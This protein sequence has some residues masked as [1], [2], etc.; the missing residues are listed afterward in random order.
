MQRI[1]SFYECLTKKEDEKYI[2]RHRG[3]YEKVVLLQDTESSL[4]SVCLPFPLCRKRFA[5]RNSA[6]K[7]GPLGGIGPGYFD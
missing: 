5:L 6:G 4:A 3:F 7:S 2:L 1:C